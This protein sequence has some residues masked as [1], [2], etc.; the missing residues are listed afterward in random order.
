MRGHNRFLLIA[1]PIAMNGIVLGCDS[2]PENEEFSRVENV[3]GTDDR[4]DIRSSDAP[5]GAIGRLETGCT[6]TLVG[7]RLVLTAAH[8]TVTTGAGSVKPELKYFAVNVVEGTPKDK[9]FIE[10][11]WYGTDNPDGQN[12]DRGKDWAVLKLS[13]PLGDRFQPMGVAVPNLGTLPYSTNLAGYSTDRDSGNS[14]SVHRGCTIRQIAGDRLLHDCDAKAGI[15]G[16]PMFKIA[17]NAATIEAISVSEYRNG[18]ASSVD[19]PDWKPELANVAI[20]ASAFEP[21][22]KALLR[23]VDD[24]QAAPSLPGV[25]FKTNPN[26]PDPIDPPPPAGD[27]IQASQ[28]VSMNVVRSRADDLVD[29]AE[30]ASTLLD[31][32]ALYARQQGGHLDTYRLADTAGFAVLHLKTAVATAEHPDNDATS[33]AQLA[34][35]LSDALR[36]YHA[37]DTDVRA[38]TTPQYF[39][40]QLASYSTNAANLIAS[41]RRGLLR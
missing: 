22:V 15:S 19:A 38:C 14:A 8:C 26:Q 28:I 32:A 27:D 39:C 1:V 7:K 31:N 18:A 35:A 6:G 20:S 17:G 29:N 37:F 24:G 41:L 25:L 40:N 33:P 10:Q 2:R 5:F 13:K 30:R 36:A 12:S 21:T 3:F 16:G 23:T 11:I 9:A 4:T 34:K